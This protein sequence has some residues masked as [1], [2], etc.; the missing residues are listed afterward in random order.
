MS[1]NGSSVIGYALCNHNLFQIIKDLIVHDF[2]TCSS[3]APIQL[4]NCY[5]EKVRMSSSNDIYVNDL[6]RNT[7]KNDEFRD[8]IT[9]NVQSINAITDQNIC[10]SLDITDGVNNI[11]HILYT[12]SLSTYGHSRYTGHKTYVERKYKSSWI[13]EGCECARK[14]FREANRRYRQT[15]CLIMF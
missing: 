10:S 7:D 14:E 6:K 12:I 4:L 9:S 8:T 3:H 2:Q 15:G 5:Y 1:A 13:N 11:S